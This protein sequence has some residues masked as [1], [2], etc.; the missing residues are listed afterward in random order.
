MGYCAIRLHLDAQKLCTIVLSLGK[1]NKIL[2]GAAGSPDVFQ[3]EMSSFMAGLKFVRVYLDD[4]LV[5][6]KTAFQD[7]RI[8][9]DGLRVNT[10]KTILVE[11]PLITLAIGCH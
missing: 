10:K 7:Q 2:I 4:V 8:R 5:I 11:K 6:S 1:C 3:T 9:D